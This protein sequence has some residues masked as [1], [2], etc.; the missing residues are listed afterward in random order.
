MTRKCKVRHA[1]GLTALKNYARTQCLVSDKPSSAVSQAKND[2]C[3]ENFYENELFLRASPKFI[4]KEHI[5]RLLTFAAAVFGIERKI[6]R[7]DVVP[8]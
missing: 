3:G 5:L 2:V 6:I 7:Q 4:R 8:F 1:A